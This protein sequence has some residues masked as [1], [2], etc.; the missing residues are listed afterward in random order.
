MLA[1]NTQVQQWVQ[2][3]GGTVPEA[4]QTIS[5][6]ISVDGGTPLAV[7]ERDTRSGVTRML[8][9]IHLKDVVKLGMRVRFEQLRSM[10]IRTSS[11]TSRSSCGAMASWS[12]SAPVESRCRS[13]IGRRV[14][15]P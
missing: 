1:R 12:C 3:A 14:C 15:A 2:A 5:H 6:G 7:A 8:G 11:T 9:V 4:V 10:G 13:S